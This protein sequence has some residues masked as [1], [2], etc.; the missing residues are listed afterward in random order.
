MII[1]AL[2][3]RQS[4]PKTQYL[5]ALGYGLTLGDRNAL[6][7]TVQKAMACPTSAPVRQI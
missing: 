5:R 4:N 1:S 2:R 6:T 7:P 3:T